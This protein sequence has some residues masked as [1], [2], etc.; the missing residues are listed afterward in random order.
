MSRFL[1]ASFTWLWTCLDSTIRQILE[2]G[3]AVGG[4]LGEGGGGGAQYNTLPHCSYNAGLAAGQRPSWLSAE[5]PQTVQVVQRPGSC[6][7]KSS[8][9]S[10]RQRD[11]ERFTPVGKETALNYVHTCKQNTQAD[12]LSVCRFF[13][14][15]LAYLWFMLAVAG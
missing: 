10:S 13:Y 15:H 4:W 3:A 2:E 11:Y 12:V 6:K 7:K 8:N 5:F 14:V 9:E 1:P